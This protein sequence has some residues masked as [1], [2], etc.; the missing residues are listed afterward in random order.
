VTDSQNVRLVRSLFEAWGR[1]DFGAADW[2]DPEIEYVVPDGPSPGSWRGLRGGEQYL[3]QYLSAWDGY[4]VSAEGYRDVDAERVLVLVRRHGRGKTSGLE[5]GEIEAGGA[6][7]FH[8]RGGKVVQLTLYWD[9][10]RALADLGL[11][12]E[13]DAE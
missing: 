1:G 2:A 8:L 12:P 6:H 13:R 9:R 11:E 7:V 10:N 4:H 5:L 3:R